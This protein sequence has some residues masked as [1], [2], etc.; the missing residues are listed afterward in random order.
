MLAYPDSAIGFIQTHFNQPYKFH[1]D[2]KLNENIIQGLPPKR[3]IS[4]LEVYKEMT[5]CFVVYP[6]FPKYL[7]NAEYIISIKALLLFHNDAHNHKITGILKQL[8]ILTVAPTCFSSRRNHH[9]GAIFVL[10]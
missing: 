5:H 10:S 2:T 9:Q 3:I 7:M 4:F 6:F 1:G 8:K